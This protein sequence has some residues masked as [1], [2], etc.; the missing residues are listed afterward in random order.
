MTDDIH[1]RALAAAVR[2]SLACT[3]GAATLAI[4]CEPSPRATATSAPAGPGIVGAR[5]EPARVPDDATVSAEVY[6]AAA[7]RRADPLPTTMTCEERLDVALPSEGDVAGTREVARR[8][9]AVVQCC[10]AL[11]RTET[12]NNPHFLE[13]CQLVSGQ[14]PDAEIPQ[15]CSPW[16]P[17]VPPS[18]G[19]TPGRRIA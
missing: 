10:A 15:A 13:C 7:Q 5:T 11:V 19:W 9:Q 12:W 17:A 16:G 4:A 2:L 1:R 6:G 8:T 3:W 18:I 14:I